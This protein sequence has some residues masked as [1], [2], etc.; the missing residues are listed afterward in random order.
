MSQHIVCLQRENSESRV[1]VQLGWD[2]PFSVF[3]MVVFEEPTAGTDADEYEEK[4]LYSN[5]D[6]PRSAGR[7]LD[8]FKQVAIA[9]GCNVP[10]VMWR[11]A[12]QDREF[13]VVNKTVFYTPQGDLIEP[14]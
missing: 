14:F 5:C 13:D 10:D 4:I 8:Y 3:Y 2:R 7:E 1:R 12:Y 9:L 6:D 11:A